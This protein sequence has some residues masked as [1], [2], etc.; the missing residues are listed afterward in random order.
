MKFVFHFDEENIHRH[1]YYAGDFSNGHPIQ[2][3]G[4][5][6]G[7]CWEVADENDAV[8]WVLNTESVGT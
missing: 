3:T 8:G 1:R 4:K 6:D 2:V 7:L 5:T